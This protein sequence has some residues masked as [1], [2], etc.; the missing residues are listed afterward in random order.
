MQLHEQKTSGYTNYLLTDSKSVIAMIE[1]DHGTT[2]F[3]HI[4]PQIHFEKQARMQGM[5][6][7]FI[8]PVESTCTR[9]KE[10]YTNDAHLST[11]LRIPNRSKGH[12]R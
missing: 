4:D 9:P 12:V 7:V 5:F 2:L 8:I 6:Q 1:C 10:S 3:R 11:G